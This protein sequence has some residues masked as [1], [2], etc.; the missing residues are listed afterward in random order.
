MLK[1]NSK[2]WCCN[3]NNYCLSSPFFYNEDNE[4]MYD[5][6]GETGGVPVSEI[7]F[8]EHRQNH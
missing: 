1:H 2:Q 4:E 3:E 8:F 6:G 7:D 5:L